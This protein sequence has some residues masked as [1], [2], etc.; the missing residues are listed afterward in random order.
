LRTIRGAVD[1]LHK[2]ILP[3][4]KVIVKDSV[5]KHLNTAHLKEH[6]KE[7]LE[8]DIDIQKLLDNRKNIDGTLSVMLSSLKNYAS[9]LADYLCHG[10]VV[11]SGLKQ[12]SS[13]AQILGVEEK[14]TMISTIENKIC[15]MIKKRVFGKKCKTILKSMEPFYRDQ[16][17]LVL[18]K[19]ANEIIKKKKSK[20]SIQDI[21]VKRPHKWL[22]QLL[23]VAMPLFLLSVQFAY[24]IFI[25][26]EMAERYDN[27]LCPGLKDGNEHEVDGNVRMLVA[28][29]G[30]Y[31]T[32]K[33]VGLMRQYMRALD[34]NAAA[35]SRSRST[36]T[37]SKTERLKELTMSLKN[38]EQSLTIAV[39][40]PSTWVAPLS[41]SGVGFGSGGLVTAS[42]VFP[43]QASMGSAVVL[44][45]G[46]GA[47]AEAD[48]KP[49]TTGSEL[50][51]IKTGCGCPLP[52]SAA[53][54]L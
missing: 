49:S 34:G 32:V 33:S 7:P 41:T 48:V 27:G 30:A 1:Q 50:P 13:G 43:D 19:E 52:P 14:E 12:K 2:Q 40:Q 36:N 16:Y 5:E 51:E 21:V 11:N 44:G 18:Q 22:R 37:T 54:L 20:P 29:V 28:F 47:K 8:P 38:F 23:T 45:Q 6:L 35:T 25:F 9:T 31:F 42:V 10:E 53:M 4:V 39:K 46:F 15:A 3:S 26:L 17:T 24:L